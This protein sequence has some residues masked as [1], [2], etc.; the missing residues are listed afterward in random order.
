[1]ENKEG[2]PTGG[3]GMG[4]APGET[5]NVGEK[6][7]EML[8]QYTKN[9]AEAFVLLNQLAVYVWN[10]YKIDWK[11]TEGQPGSASRKDRYM[12]FISDL[13]NNPNIQDEIEGEGEGKEEGKEKAA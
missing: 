6:I 2:M 11:N 4:E 12:N 9:P 1:M 8:G 10:Q 13:L 7:L 5:V 3:E